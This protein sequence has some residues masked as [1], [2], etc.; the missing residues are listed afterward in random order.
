MWVDS[1][2]RTVSRP[3]TWKI[4]S[5]RLFVIA[6]PVTVPL[7]SVAFL[8]AVLLKG[9]AVLLLPVRRMWSEPPRARV[10]Y[11][12]YG[13]R[14]QSKP[15]LSV[16]EAPEEDLSGE[17]PQLASKQRLRPTNPNRR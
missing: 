6:F 1:L 14:R 10:G 9:F 17:W 2:W 16:V 13:V 7:W 15:R 12:G 4:G 11:H 5:R 8:A 3:M